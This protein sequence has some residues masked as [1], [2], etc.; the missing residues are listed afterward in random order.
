[1]KQAFKFECEI[2]ILEENK[3]KIFYTSQTFTEEL[4]RNKRVVCKKQ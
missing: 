1:M 4:L 3:T 2:K